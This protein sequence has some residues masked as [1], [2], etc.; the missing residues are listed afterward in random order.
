[1]TIHTGEKP[2]QCPYCDKSFRK[3]DVLVKH[4]RTHTGEKP[5]GPCDVS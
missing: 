1:M 5:F 4:K 3:S 2:H